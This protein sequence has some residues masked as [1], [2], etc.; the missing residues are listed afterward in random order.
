MACAP[1]TLQMRVTPAICAAAAMTGF[2]LPSLEGGVT[3]TISFTPA[4]LAGMT[5]MSTVLG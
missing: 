4:I 2:T 3:I 1:P 5:F